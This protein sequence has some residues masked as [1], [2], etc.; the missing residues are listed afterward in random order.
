[1]SNPEY[2]RLLR[3]SAGDLRERLPGTGAGRE[4]IAALLTDLPDETLP[5]LIAGLGG[6]DIAEL[7]DAF[8]E[9]DDARPT[10]IFAYTIKGH[11]LPNAGHPQNHSNLLLP[12]QLAHLAAELGESADD[13]WRGF[14]PDSA[15][16]RLRR[17]RRAPTQG[18]RAAAGQAGDPCR[19]RQ[20]DHHPQLD[21]T[22]PGPVAA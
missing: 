21:P 7:M 13:P 3:C 12:D 19:L 8:G 10:I 4:A 14:D 6:H 5:R 17:G 22:I 18:P 15:A 2:Q 9:I 20:N 1:M 16:A 11:G